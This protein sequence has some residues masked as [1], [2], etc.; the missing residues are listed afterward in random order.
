MRRLVGGIWLTLLL[1]LR[2]G[3]H[4]IFV[5]AILGVFVRYIPQ[6]AICLILACGRAISRRIP[7]YAG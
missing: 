3:T 4:A 2:R 1:V 7:S 5:K 6:M